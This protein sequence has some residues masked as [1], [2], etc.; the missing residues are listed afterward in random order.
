MG[1]LII[2]GFATRFTVSAT[3]GFGV[4]SVRIAAKESLLGMVSARSKLSAIIRRLRESGEI[5][6]FTRFGFIVGRTV[7]SVSGCCVVMLVSV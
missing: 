4:V 6:L 3:A 2:T 7:V 1:R 5:L